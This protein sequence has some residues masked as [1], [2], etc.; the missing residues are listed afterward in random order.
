MANIPWPLISLFILLQTQSYSAA[1]EIILKLRNFAEQPVQGW[2]EM[3]VPNEKTATASWV[4]VA[5]TADARLPN[6]KCTPPGIIFRASSYDQ[7][8]FLEAPEM[9]KSCVIGEIIFRF[10]RKDYADLIKKA[11]SDQSGTL[12]S[13]S[14]NAKYLHNSM[15]AALEK[16]NFADAATRSMLLYDTIEKELGQEAAEPYRVLATDLGA[17]PITST[18]P[19]IFDPK[20]KKYVLSPDTVKAVAEFQ[21]KQG[22][23]ASGHLTWGT[24][25]KLPNFGGVYVGM[26]VN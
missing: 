18:Q 13:A 17:S 15:A 9:M 6:A 5:T 4:V 25:E 2:V 8:Y 12:H 19:L 3:Q 11:L 24:A 7:T 26:T 14:A 10:R 21:K 23:S 22:L 16:S 20:Q 1:D